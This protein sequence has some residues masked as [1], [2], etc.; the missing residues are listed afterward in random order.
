MKQVDNNPT[1]TIRIS[2]MDD[3]DVT[4][5]TVWVRQPPCGLV[6]DIEEI[7]EKYIPVI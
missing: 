7:L 2:N 1:W 4:Y 3:P 5:V 6:S